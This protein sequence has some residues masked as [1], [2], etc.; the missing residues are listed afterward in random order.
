MDG[1][2]ALPPSL[3]PAVA[4]PA[5]V[6]ATRGASFIPPARVAL[7]LLTTWLFCSVPT[8]ASASSPKTTQ[9]NRPLVSAFVS[10]LALPSATQAR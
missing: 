4:G 9:I 2:A 7:A 5:V 1:E 6:V 3:P 10:A 8:S